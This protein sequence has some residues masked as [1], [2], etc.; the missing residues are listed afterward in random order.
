MDEL[1]RFKSDIDF[2]S[3]AATRGYRVDRRESSRGYVVLRHPVTDDKIVV[4]RA[5]QD[6][7]WIYFSVRDPR[8]HGSIVDFVQRRDGGTLGAVRRELAAW[9]GASPL[10]PPTWT[11]ERSV[12][13]RATDRALV[14]R[15]FARARA[16]ERSAYLQSRGISTS[17]LSSARFAGT[18]REDPRGNVLFPH[19]DAEGL[20]GFESKNRGWT[21]FAAGGVR[22]LWLSNAFAHDTALVFVESAIDALSFHQVHDEPPF[23][24]A[25]TAGSLGAYQRRIVAETATEL[26]ADATLVL[27]FDRDAAGDRLAEQVRALC[28]RASTRVYP[29]HGKDWNEHLQWSARVRQRGLPRGLGRSRER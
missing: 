26:P 13:P 8:D 10:E 15:A 1:D 7:H 17:V 24:Y 28:A 14:A 9:S 11:V 23:R 6:Q 27:A 12:E 20:T 25:S 19:A 21:S 22:A 2:V 18:F 29:S 5:R 4:S 3:F 16:V